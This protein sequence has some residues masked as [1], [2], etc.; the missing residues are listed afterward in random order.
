MKYFI[1]I[2]A[3]F[4]NSWCFSQSVG[5]GTNT[6]DSNSILDIKDSLR[7]VILPRVD[8]SKRT[9]I[10]NTQGM[11]LFDI[12]NKYFWVNDGTNWVNLP[13]KGNSRG[14]LLFWNN[15]QWNVLPAG[16]AGQYLSLAPGTSLPTW[17]D[18]NIGFGNISTKVASNI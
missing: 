8:S 5:I 7:G 12:S 10:P 15:S 3:L 2:V 6:P 18:V 16:N 9:A 14:D 4:F 1:L 11:I 17:V 13:P